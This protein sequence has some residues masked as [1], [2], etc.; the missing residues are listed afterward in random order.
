MPIMKS[1]RETKI[2]DV[3]FRE[4][5][6]FKTENF[7]FNKLLTQD[8]LA[9]L[10]DIKISPISLLCR[11]L[12]WVSEKLSLGSRIIRSS[13]LAI[14]ENIRGSQRVVEIVKILGAT[15]YINLS[16]GVD[17]YSETNFRENGITLRILTPYEGSFSNIL[18]RITNENI[19][20]LKS[21]IREQT[22]FQIQK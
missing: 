22:I 8:E 3:T 5:D 4:N 15:E 13:D 7:R 17:L 14:D 20:S 19:E 1:S 12:E 11:Q 21:E 9:Y 16:G 10:F 2:K 6:I 18:D